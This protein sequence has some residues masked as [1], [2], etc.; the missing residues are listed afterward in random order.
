MTLGRGTYFSS[1]VIA[2]ALFSVR[3]F[4]CSCA[5]PPPTCQAVG[6]SDL[7]FVGTVT[8]IVTR[9]GEFKRAR[10]NIDVTFKGALNKTIELFDDGM[11]D[12]PDLQVGR[13]YLMYT[14]GSPKC[15]GSC[16]GL[17]SQP[18]DRGRGRGSG[19]S[20]QYS[21]G[22][23]ATY[24]DGTVRFRPDEPEDSDLGDAG[25]TPLK[26]VRVT[27]SGNGTQF[28]TTT[29]SAGRYSF[30][31]LAPGEYAVSAELSG[32]RVDWA[33]E[34]VNLVANGCAE[35]NLLMKVD[36]RVRGRIRDDNGE[37]VSGA[38]V[39][40]VSTNQQLKRWE[41]PVLLDV[42]DEIGDYTIEGIPPGEYYFGVN[43][44]STPTR[45][46]PYPSTYYPN[47]PDLHKAQRIVVVA[48]PSVQEFDLRV[49]RRLPIVTIREESKQ[50]TA[51]RRFLRIILRYGLRSRGCTVR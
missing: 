42:S 14:S 38:L 33:P 49:S 20:Q 4:G 22:R 19:I 31:N 32:Y 21:A 27:L 45:E 37:P 51:G 24:I 18:P 43:I 23:T 17:Q 2:A 48:G 5:V 46:H 44:R 12:G 8:E 47:T 35:A 1:I 3:A 39:E 29:T 15:S 25:R 7:V 6:Q 13:Q 16:A 50:P 11:C 40:M 34:S 30:P 26:D 36:R 28:S 41:Q 10:M 9:P